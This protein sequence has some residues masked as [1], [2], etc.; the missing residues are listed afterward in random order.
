MTSVR[1]LLLLGAGAVLLAQPGPASAGAREPGPVVAGEA[2]ALGLLDTA[3]RA[4]RTR[5]WSG[6]QYVSTWRAGRA[7]AAVVEVAHDPATGTHV[8]DQAAG[9]DA[10]TA[11]VALDE[12]LLG[13]L[14]DRYDLV[15]AGDGT[16]AGRDVRIVEAR[17]DGRV[18][19]RTWLDRA[20]GLAVRQEVYDDEGARLR[21]SVFVD[22]SVQDDGAAAP[23]RLVAPAL[24][25]TALSTP[26]AEAVGGAGWPVPTELPG[27]YALFEAGRPAHDGGQ[28]LH[29]AYSDGLS[30]LSLFS[31]PGDDAAPR[32]DY[33]EHDLDGTPVWVSEQTPER[34]VWTGG[35][36]VFTLVSDAAHE[37][38]LA[39]VAALPRAERV[40][41]GTGARLRRGLARVGS[42]FN[43]FG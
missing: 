25:I 10:T 12:R 42:W 2:T 30:T 29:L 4:A 8:T 3:A 36:Q 19:G 13:L 20:S 38:L 18:E 37:D 14:A 34:V 32:G 27:G 24:P 5:T 7:G 35:G 11:P 26:R 9:A 39:V 22:L 21:S 17:R 41:D 16:C 43:P 6:T 28:V 15:V 40:D 31:Q 33:A 23:L 1:L